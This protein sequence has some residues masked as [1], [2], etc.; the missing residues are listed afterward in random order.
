MED[1]I[2][3]EMTKQD[4]RLLYSCVTDSYLNW[5]GGE[6]Q[7]QQALDSMKGFLFRALLEMTYQD[8]DK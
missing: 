6:P 3:F 2:T 1:L 5:A 7:E 4:V 8:P